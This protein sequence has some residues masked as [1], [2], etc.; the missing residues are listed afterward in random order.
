VW[1]FI[2]FPGIRASNGNVHAA[3]YR[4]NEIRDNVGHGRERVV[5][6]HHSALLRCE[7]CLHAGFEGF[8]PG[9][10]RNHLRY[11]ALAA[12]LKKG[13]EPEV[14]AS[15]AVQ[16][17]E[18]SADTL[19]A[20]EEKVLRTIELLKM[21]RDAKVHAEAQVTRLKE[22]AEEREEEIQGLRDENIRLRKEREEVRGRVEKMLHQ[23]EALT[24]DAS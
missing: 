20:L 14:M 3:K 15:N 9:F 1:K 5:R 16:M 8:L 12:A 23:V 13:E 2:L 18:I 17:P 22:Q 10:P 11:T 4:S 6:V 24:A 19:Q 7:H 21:A